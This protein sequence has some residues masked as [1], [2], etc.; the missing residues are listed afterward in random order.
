MTHGSSPTLGVGMVGYAFMGRAHSQAWRSAAAFFD[1]PYTPAMVALV[2]RSHD[3][4]GAAARRLGWASAET[5]WRALINRDDVH[6][7]DICTPGDTHC[8]IAVAALQAGKHVIC[9]KPLANT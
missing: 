2:G 5:D 3:R 1:L 8:E 6:V 9:E 7:V 4:V